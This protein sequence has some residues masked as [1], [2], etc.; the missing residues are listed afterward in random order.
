LLPTIFKEFSR[1][2]ILKFTLT[3]RMFVLKM[4]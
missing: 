2:C 1:Y 4:K 3:F